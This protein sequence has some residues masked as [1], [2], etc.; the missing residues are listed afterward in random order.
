LL[1]FAVL[2]LGG[3]LTATPRRGGGFLVTAHLPLPAAAR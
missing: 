1:P 2:A 3:D